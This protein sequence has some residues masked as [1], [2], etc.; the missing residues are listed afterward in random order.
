V[1]SSD[2]AANVKVYIRRQ[3]NRYHSSTSCKSATDRREGAFDYW[4]LLSSA[5]VSRLEYCD[6]CAAPLHP[7]LM[8][9]W[10]Q[11]LAVRDAVGRCP[12]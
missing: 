7:W 6:V 9:R 5:H 8:P 10:E 3:S 2:Q 12:D 1:R 4:C 11:F